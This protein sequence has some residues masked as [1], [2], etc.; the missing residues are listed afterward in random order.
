MV[1]NTN[2]DSVQFL[3]FDNKDYRMHVPTKR[4]IIIL[5]LVLFSYLL[6]GKVYAFYENGGFLGK[7]ANETAIYSEVMGSSDTS[8]E[9]T[10]EIEPKSQKSEASS[11]LNRV[12]HTGIGVI[13]VMI[14]VWF[15]ITLRLKGIYWSIFSIVNGYW[16]VT[17]YLLTIVSHKH[18]KN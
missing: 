7:P 11:S 10:I 8:A 3:P 6:I 2:S 9:Q 5:S 13:D 4:N 17:L 16:A 14:A 18:E 1:T 12:V 15:L